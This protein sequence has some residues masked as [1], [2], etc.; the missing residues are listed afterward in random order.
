MNNV[1]A[2]IPARGGSKSIPE[3]N[4]KLLGGKP[5]VSWT[6]ETALACGLERIVV[7]TEDS[8]VIDIASKHDVDIQIRNPNLAK[9]NISMYEVL[10]SEIFKLN[11]VPEIVLLLQPTS[12]F[13]SKNHISIA[14]SYFLNNID[15]Y[16]SLI[17]VERVPERYSPYAMIVEH[18][19]EK[20]VLF[21][22]LIGLKEKIVSRFTGKKFVGPELSGY[23]VSQR[24]LRRQ[25]LPQCWLPTGETYLLKT[26]NLKTGSLYGD[27]VML[28]E[29]ESSININSP[30]DFQKAEQL[31]AQ[32]S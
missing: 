16:D 10:R 13:R 28:L 20:R 22:K 18:Q 12:P 21:R 14:L 17:S 1:V 25:D 4:I 6:I 5:L 11:P 32:K 7:N 15:T 2:F 9:D 8:K 31:C 30:E 26:S 24:M 19:G 23:P 27:N 3:K 29:C